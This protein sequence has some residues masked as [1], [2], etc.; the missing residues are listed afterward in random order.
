M[1]TSKILLDYVFVSTI[2]G[3]FGPFG[4][5]KNGDLDETPKYTVFVLLT[6]DM[7][8][9]ILE[10]SGNFNYLIRLI[11]TKIESKV[12]CL[13][14]LYPLFQVEVSMSQTKIGAERCFVHEKN[15]GPKK[16]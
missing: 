8:D 2:F 10:E 3:E 11:A 9:N 16:F 14:K 4:S 1:D 6:D 7:P 13:E 12:F 15:I 5:V